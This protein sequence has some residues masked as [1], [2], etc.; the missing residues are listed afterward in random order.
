MICRWR[1]TPGCAAVAVS[2]GAHPREDLERL[3]P[4]ACV[5]SFARVDAM[6]EAKR[7]ICASQDLPERG[8]G[9]RF[10]V[11]DRSAATAP[12]FVGALPRQGAR[13]S[14]PLRACPGR[15][16]LATTASSSTCPV[17]TWCVRRT[18]QRIVPETG[19]LHRRPMQRTA[20]DQTR[21][22]EEQDGRRLSAEQQGNGSWLKSIRAAGRKTGNARS[23]RKLAL[24]ALDE[25]RRAR[26]WGIFF[27]TLTFIYLFALLFVA[28]GWLRRT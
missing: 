21:Q 10:T 26:H 13:L 16:R 8:K 12:A 23:S 1:R 19:L 14:E 6:A 17:Y 24:A 2:Y 20:P 25:Q 7:L 18:V 5:D 9:V 27:K 22:C 15:T 28:F 11:R 3:Q 4:L